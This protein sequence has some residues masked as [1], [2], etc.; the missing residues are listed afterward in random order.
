MADFVG[1]NPYN[2]TR[3][4][5]GHWDE[6]QIVDA[7][8]AGGF[9]PDVPFGWGTICGKIVSVISSCGVTSVVSYASTLGDS[10]QTQ[11]NTLL[12]SVYYF[13]TPSPVLIDLTVIGNGAAP[14]T[15]HWPIVWKMEYTG[16][17]MIIHLANCPWVPQGHSVLL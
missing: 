10:W 7:I 5:D 11:W 6:G 16:S 3:V 4:S 12:Q 14:L 1:K 8:E 9:G 13:Q 15:A 2:L 17:D